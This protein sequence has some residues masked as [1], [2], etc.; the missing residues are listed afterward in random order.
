[1]KELK[2]LE[3]L[4]YIVSYGEVDFKEDKTEEQVVDFIKEARAELE[5]LQAPKTCETCKYYTK[6]DDAYNYC[7]KFSYLNGFV[8]EFF[9]CNSYISKDTQC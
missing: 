7:D 8:D 6:C 4:N 1:M 5:A 3:I 2:A 9:C